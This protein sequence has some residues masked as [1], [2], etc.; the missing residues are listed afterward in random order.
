MAAFA[1]SVDCHILTGE[2]W[3]NVQTSYITYNIADD[4]FMEVKEAVMDVL[5]RWQFIA[6]ALGLR[7]AQA[8]TIKSTHRGDVEASMDD[9][10][11]I[12]LRRAHNENKH[13]PPT[14]RKLVQAITA[15]T[16]GNNNALARAIAKAHPS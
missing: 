2:L 1:D 14:W 11:L 3:F 8:E 9:A 5:H 6:L 16:G 7:P 13:G 15:K 10:I 12:W 4:D